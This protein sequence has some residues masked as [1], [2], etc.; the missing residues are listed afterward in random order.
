MDHIGMAP[1]GLD[2]VKLDR[3]AMLSALATT[4]LAAGAGAPAF[5]RAARNAATQALLDG[6]V[7]E[8][9]V[10]GGIIAILEPGRFRPT[11]LVSGK[12]SFD[13]GTKVTPDTLWRVYS[14]TK[15]ITGVAVMQQVATGRIGLDTP[16]S[17]VMPE[18]RAM[19]VLLDPTKDLQSRPAEKPILVRHLLTHTAGFSYTISGNEAL[20]KE[21][22]RLGLMPMSASL[23]RQPGD[24][25]TPGL[26]E[27]MQRLATVPLRTEPGT[28]YRYSIGLDVAGAMLERM[29]GRTL[30]T[31][32]EQQLFGPLGMKDTGFWVND[33]QRRRLAGSYAWLDPKTFKPSSTP[34]LVD[35]P[36]KTEWAERPTMLAGGAGLVS[37]ASDY[38]RFAQMMLNEGM[39]EGKMLLPRTTARLAMANMMPLGV[40]FEKTQGYGSGG[41]TALFDTS[42]EPEGSKPGKWGWGGAAS[43]T[44]FVDPLRGE[45]VVMMLQSL[46]AADPPNANQLAGA[47]NRDVQTG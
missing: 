28:A 3:R 22:R 20:E 16:I 19:Q 36:A 2:R 38:A 39:F 7:A 43:T 29:T 13:G 33:D 1:M 17:A 27:Y 10:P 24:A 11:Y 6:Y 41:R 14:M 15:P 25:P 8:G 31:V 42:S 21:Y 12:T 18:F 47:R 45:A 23:G 32:F 34:T 35:S 30:D 46:A 40:F 44:F 9:K 4:A 5:A 26:T 37:S